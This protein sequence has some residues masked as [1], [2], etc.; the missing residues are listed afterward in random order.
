[1]L[2]KYQNKKTIAVIPA[3]MQSSRFYGKPLAKILGKE[4][5]QWVY[6]I[7]T[8]S[9]FLKEV[10]VATDH[11]D[12]RRFCEEKHIPCVMTSPEHKN[13]AERSNEVCQKVKAEFV[14]EVQGDEP[15][16]LPQDVDSFI[17]QAFDFEQFDVVTQY[18]RISQEEALNPNAVKLVVG[19]GQKAL[20]FSRCPIPYNFKVKNPDY[21]KQVGLYVWTADALKRF[22]A[23]PT[24]Y[25]ERAEDTHMLRLVESGFDGRLVETKISS[26]GVD[27]PDDIA[28]AEE[29][30]RRRQQSSL[31]GVKSRE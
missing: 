15:T 10:Y 19:P 18:T 31:T 25:L 2:S 26:V 20:F 24:G 21:Y 5:L 4:M 11:D 13:C 7:C 22:S 23:T 6:E 30:L 16:L 29:F 3:R 12:I 1:M 14:I 28:Q 9:N 17:D 8:A 27:V